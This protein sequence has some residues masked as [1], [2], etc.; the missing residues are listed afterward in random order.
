MIE[1]NLA[2][3]TTFMTHFSISAMVGY[4][5]Y[6]PPPLQDFKIWVKEELER[7]SGWLVIHTQ[8]LGK[9]F[10]LI[11][12][13]DLPDRDATLDFS[14]WF[15]GRKFLYTFPWV[16]ASMWPR[17]TTIC[18][19]FGSNFLSGLLCW[20]VQNSRWPIASGRYCSTWEETS[21]VPTRSIKHASYGTS[22]KWYLWVYK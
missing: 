18:Y 14:P 17:E 12:F 9:N 11:E 21:I 2:E 5:T 20:K 8:Y 3:T 19:M 4:F 7:N 15:Y 22:Q 1:H 13:V 6:R 10:F 16:P